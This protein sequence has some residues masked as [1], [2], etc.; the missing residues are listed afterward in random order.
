MNISV[1]H[2]TLKSVPSKSASDRI[3]QSSSTEPHA[4]TPYLPESEYD[5]GLTLPFNP[6]M[7]ELACMTPL[8]PRGT[9]NAGPRVEEESEPVQVDHGIAMME[10]SLE[11][12]VPDVIT[13]A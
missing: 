2:R 1:R 5:V 9:P 12:G 13:Q 4:V 6:V 11:L 3:N 10:E 8:E 7:Y